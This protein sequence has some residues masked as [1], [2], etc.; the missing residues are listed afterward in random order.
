MIKKT[1]CTISA[2]V[3]FWTMPLFSTPF[4]DGLSPLKADAAVSTAANALDKTR[5]EDD[6]DVSE[7]PSSATESVR[8]VSFS[9]YCFA[10]DLINSGNYALYV[11]VYYPSGKALS[12]RDGVH[13]V[14]MA[15]TYDE[16]GEPIRYENCALRYLSASES[17][18]VVKLRVVGNIDAIFANARAMEEE[19]GERRY[20]VAGVQLL[21]MGAAGAKDYTIGETYLYT[22]YAKGYGSE[23]KTVSTLTVANEKTISLNV[24]STYYSPEGTNGKDYTQD[25]L[26]SVYFSVPNEYIEK[27]GVLYAVHAEFIRAVL[28]PAIITDNLNFCNL[29]QKKV[30]S[31]QSDFGYSA[32]GL[33][34]SYGYTEDIFGNVEFRSD[35][36][37]DPS[38]AL[39][40][41]LNAETGLGRLDR[42]DQVYYTGGAPVEGYTVD[43][44]RAKTFIY[45]HSVNRD[46]AGK[47]DSR[48]FSSIDEKKEI[49]YSADD[50]FSL[51]SERYTMEKFLFFCW[52]QKVSGETFEVPA[53][54]EI[55]KCES[56]DQIERDYYINA[57]DFDAVRALYEETDSTVYIFHFACDDY[58]SQKGMLLKNGV[59]APS[60]L[61]NVYIAKQTAYIDFDVIDITMR[62]S[63]GKSTVLGVVSD[64]ID[65][66]R[67]YT[68]PV[69]PVKDYIYVVYIVMTV[70][71]AGIILTIIIKRK[72]RDG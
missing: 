13:T 58:F 45:D 2:A 42:I 15:L 66:F 36:I 47:Y 14:N 25:S 53:V 18:T 54:Q 68:P 63:E 4:F 16:E 24:H 60:N 1:V 56:A 57:N 49:T 21:E 70:A 33:G 17:G 3:L 65:I 26:A 51:T 40:T 8:V 52:S 22:G 19:S 30:L 6:L 67:D 10:E 32:I 11:Y 31:D 55:K 59:Q 50:N 62:N 12:V 46:V 64:P 29:L 71:L 34:D 28:N 38:D 5:V 9:E 27:Y 37:Y 7:Y 35:T 41:I 20:D 72:W 48:F 23:S 43:N 69:D 44:D 39:N 61:G